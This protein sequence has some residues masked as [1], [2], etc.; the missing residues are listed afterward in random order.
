[1][2]GLA[3]EGGGAKGA[4]HIGVYRALCELGIEIDG[5]VGTS[6]GAI[7]G[8]IIAQGDGLA[9][10]D[11]WSETENSTIFDIDEQLDTRLH[12]EGITGK[13]IAQIVELIRKHLK[14]GGIDTSQIK[15]FIETHVDEARVRNSGIDYGLVTLSLT[16]RKPLELMLEE[17]PEGQLT[18]YILASASLP[19]FKTER[20]DG[21]KLVDG[22]LWN[23]LPLSLLIDRGYDTL[24]AV[25]TNAVGRVREANHFGCAVIE[26][27]PSED[28]GSILDFNKERGRR[29]LQLGYLDALRLFK[30][31]RG[32][33]Y[34]IEPHPNNT[35]F[36]QKLSDMPPKRVQEA[37]ELLG[38]SPMPPRRM[39]F[40]RIIP[41]IAAIFGLGDTMDYEELVIAVYEMVAEKLDVE[42]LKV[43]SADAFVDA[44]NGA[45][46]ERERRVPGLLF[47]LALKDPILSRLI[48]DDLLDALISV[49]LIET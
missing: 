28:L 45:F 6:I 42:R 14:N 13:N 11:I 25:R 20:V 43:Y 9:A 22:G 33:R 40:E 39:M 44:V 49:F 23:N 29:N 8:A 19:G 7:N 30:H 3:L 35:W 24:I 38:F 15:S 16:S 21:E 12:E 17:I 18:S 5:V 1:M 46:V 48:K 4:Y 47:N 37:G 27:I 36:F 10:W 41:K 31:L 2:I 32:R 26:I 34:Y